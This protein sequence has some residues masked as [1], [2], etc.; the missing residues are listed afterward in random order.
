MNGEWSERGRRVWQWATVLGI[1]AAGLLALRPVR[2]P[3]AEIAPMQERV[4]E[5]RRVVRQTP[6]DPHRVLQLARA[7]YALAQTQALR[8]YS[9]R[10]PEVTPEPLEEVRQRYD[11]WLRGYL[12]VSSGARDAGVL[13]R[14]AADLAATPQLRAE[15]LVMAG[16]VA[17]QRGEERSAIARFREAC[18]V[19]PGWRPAWVRLAAAAEARGDARLHTEARRRLEALD[20]SAEG[21]SAGDALS[22]ESLGWPAEAGAPNAAPS[23]GLRNG[24]PRSREAD[25]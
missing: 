20:R 16:I 12:R 14:R 5:L 7:E 21:T 9:A 10:F 8:A 4:A 15:A 25:S 18:R 22:P 23:T 24:I 1:T 13:A 2:G 6:E 19:C 3:E 11:A 17:W